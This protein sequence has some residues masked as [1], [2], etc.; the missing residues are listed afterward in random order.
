MKQIL[1]HS[2]YCLFVLLSRVPYYDALAYANWVGK[3]LPTEA[4]WEKAARGG[5]TGKRFPWGDTPLTRALREQQFG[6]GR[7]TK[8]AKDGQA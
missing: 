6:L 1:K 2:F 4:E 3:R 5:F 8:L 7:N